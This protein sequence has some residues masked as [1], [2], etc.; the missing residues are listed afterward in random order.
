MKKYHFLYETTNTING[1]IYRGKHSTTNLQDGYLGSGVAFSR[2]VQKYG[3]GA[4][5]RQIVKWFDD[6][7]SLDLAER[8]WITPEFVIL[9]TNY[10]LV[11]GGQGGAAPFNLMSKEAKSERAKAAAKTKALNMT[12]EWRKS[13]G[14]KCLAWQLDEEIKKAAYEKH[15]ATMKGRTKQT[16]ES[17]VQQLETR[18]RNHAAKMAKQISGLLNTRKSVREVIA[19]MSGKTSASTV[20]RLARKIYEESSH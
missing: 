8:E 10:N 11:P 20:R 18:K 7:K 13:H 17:I 14:E 5:V 6:E 3:R 15:S 1:K 19:E 12:P 4:F 9:K 2:A 16:H